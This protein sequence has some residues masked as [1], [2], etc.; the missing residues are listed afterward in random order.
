MLSICIPIYNCN[1]KKLTEELYYQAGKQNINYEIILIDDFSENKIHTQN[2]LLKNADIRYIRLEKNIG[3]AK[4]RNF[5]LQY[6]QYEYLLFLDC[7]SQIVN[8]N[9][10]KNYLSAIN[11]NTE[12]ICGGRIYK[13]IKTQKKYRLR[14]F[15]GIQREC[16]P[17]EIRNRNPY[18]SFMSN[19]F[20][21]K[22]E[23]LKKLP[24]NEKIKGYGHEDTLFGY[25]L[26]QNSIA[27]L[28]ID[29]PAAHNFDENNREFLKKT[30]QA[31]KNLI[32]IYQNLTDKNFGEEVKLLRTYNNLKKLHF[33]IILRPA[34]SFLSPII[35]IILIKTGKTL[36]LFDIYKLFY[37][38][39]NVTKPAKI[40]K[41]TEFN[42]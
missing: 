42:G 26:K 1:V 14:Y 25:R 11:K 40:W 32:F 18:Q 6:A 7:D 29:N 41:T 15:Y 9:F 20:L 37:L 24:F 31:I 23:I 38:I 12:V 34:A 4:I 3:R 33:D 35:K 2:E 13:K 16:I 22:K 21:I 36:F 27:V 17:A 5:F 19:N 30:E 10:L 8:D 28:H 39:K